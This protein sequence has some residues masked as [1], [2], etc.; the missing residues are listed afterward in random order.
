MACP[1][2]TEFMPIIFNL[3]QNKIDFISECP[4]QTFI[5]TGIFIWCDILT[6]NVYS[7]LGEK[8]LI[9]TVMSD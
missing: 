7:D 2:P 5:L 3:S 4:Q 6:G 1:C 8:E 9:K